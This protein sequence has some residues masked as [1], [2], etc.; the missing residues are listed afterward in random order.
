MSCSDWFSIG[1]NEGDCRWRGCGDQSIR[2]WPVV[3]CH[4]SK[5]KTF[6]FVNFDGNN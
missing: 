5:K 6:R 4:F 1:L 3:G 2:E